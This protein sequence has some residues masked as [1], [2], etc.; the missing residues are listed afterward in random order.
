M[1][2]V[3]IASHLEIRE[4]LLYDNIKTS[5]FFIDLI[6]VFHLHITRSKIFEYIDAMR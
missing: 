5:F 2:S 3:I 6:A 1:K 4:F